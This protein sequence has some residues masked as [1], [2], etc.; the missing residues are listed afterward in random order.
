M[1]SPWLTPKE[2]AGYCKISLSLFNQLRRKL[3]IKFGGTLRRPRFHKDE[4][5]YWMR[6]MFRTEEQIQTDQEREKEYVRE[7][8]EIG[9]HPIRVRVGKYKASSLL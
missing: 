4:L 7:D 9:R 3:P 8:L 5:D 2:A 1:E 6:N